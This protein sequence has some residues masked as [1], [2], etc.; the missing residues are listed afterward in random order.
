M[1]KKK[2][3]TIAL[4]LSVFGNSHT[5]AQTRIDRSHNSMRIGDAVKKYQ[6]ETDNI[7][8]LSKSGKGSKEFSE[9]HENFKTDT[10]TAL[11]KGTRKYYALHSDSLLYVGL[12]NPQEKDSFYIAEPTCIFPM[13]LGSMYNG[14]F[15]CH[16]S[17]C[18]KMRY[19]KYGIYTVHADSIGT[20]TLPG[21]DTIDNALQI[22]RKRKYVYDQLGT[23][24]S[25][26][27]PI[28]SETEIL[29]ELARNSE[30]YTEVEKVLYIKGY[31][32]PI[33]TDFTLYNTNGEECTRET[34]FTPLDEEE[35][36]L[37]DEA[38]SLARNQYG[39][40]PDD[41][42]DNDDTF[43]FVRNNTDAQ[44]LLFNCGK[45][46]TANHLS[47]TIQCKLQLSDSK[48]IVYRTKDFSL[49]SSARS[50]VSVSYSGLRPGQYLISLIINNQT[51]TSNF[52]FE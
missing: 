10:I 31:R 1:R 38:N 2:L 5:F 22:C 8:D 6:I 46:I 7:W 33:V 23:D 41:A 30:T 50:E 29:H 19:H 9:T 27:A 15:A 52:I 3:L 39:A 47:G 42:G 28:Y 36:L 43:S 32:Y 40:E 12:E 4:L 25:V 13:S 45:Y 24:T 11:F 34:Y 49:D 44:E 18:D 48:G 21:G 14:V 16:V 26:V 35:A 20:L 37:L 17:Y 51:Y